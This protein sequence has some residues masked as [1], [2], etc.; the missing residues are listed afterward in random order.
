MGIVAKVLHIYRIMRV[1][2]NKG[3]Q[4]LAVQAGDVSQLFKPAI[5]GLTTVSIA[6]NIRKQIRLI[7]QLPIKLYHSHH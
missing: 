1:S 3:H 5:V 7:N 2:H 6:S 4:G